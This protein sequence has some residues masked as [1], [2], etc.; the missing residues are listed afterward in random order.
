[1]LTIKKLSVRFGQQLA[2]EIDQEIK[3]EENDR[4]GIIGSNGAGKSTLINSLLGLVPY[5]GEIDTKLTPRNMAVHLQENNYSNNVTVKLIMETVLRTKLKENGELQELITYFDFEKCLGKHFNK[6]SG[7]QKQRLTLILVMLQKADL[8]FFDEV[9]SGL[10][11]ETRQILMS[12][13][14]NWYNERS[15][16]LCVVSHYYDELEK[17]TNKLLLLD[18]GHVIAFGTLETLFNT[19]CGYSVITVEDTPLTQTFFGEYRQLKAPSQVLALACRNH[20]DEY[21]IVKRCIQ[22]N[23][24][25]KR[26]NNDIEIMTLN[27]KASKEVDYGEFNI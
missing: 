25:Y 3:F 20:E 7:G 14:T 26:R 16:T 15:G 17:L 13:L 19:Y 18:K 10:D 5:K 6:L 8:T 1:M 2:L 9:S 21:Q 23:I 24:N 22:S 12:K 11:F 4:I 27:A